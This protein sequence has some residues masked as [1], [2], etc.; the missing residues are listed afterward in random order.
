[1]GDILFTTEAPLGNV[2]IVDIDERFALG[3]V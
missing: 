3:K 1:M 2:A